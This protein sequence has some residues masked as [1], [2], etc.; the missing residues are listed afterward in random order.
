MRKLVNY[1]VVLLLMCPLV[2]CGNRDDPGTQTRE[3]S[4]PTGVVTPKQ[5]GA[6][7]SPKTLADSDY[8][9]FGRVFAAGQPAHASKTNPHIVAAHSVYLCMQGNTSAMVKMYGHVEPDEELGASFV[10]FLKE[11]GPDMEKYRGKEVHLK[12]HGYMAGKDTSVWYYY[13][14]DAQGLPWDRTPWV[15]L[16]RSNVDKKCALTGI[17]LNLPEEDE[18][19]MPD[20]LKTAK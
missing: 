15:S 16:H 8:F 13:M 1:G 20:G 12:F 9:T 11:F 5:E 3:T 2:S 14:T 10:T 7:S 19:P 18:S 17:F 4:T 6:A